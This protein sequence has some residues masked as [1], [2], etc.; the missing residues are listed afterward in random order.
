MRFFSWRRA[1][2]GGVISLVVAAT[3]GV[4]LPPGGATVT[5]TASPSIVVDATQ[6]GHQI[7]PGLYGENQ[8]FT[9]GGK[10][11]LDLSSIAANPTIV[12]I[13]A[14]VLAW[15]QTQ[16]FTGL[17]FPGG[18]VAITYN[19]HNGL[20]PVLDRPTCTNTAGPPTACNSY[21]I[22]EA[23]ELV[24]A[25][26]PQAVFGTEMVLNS[27]TTAQDA[28]DFVQFV[29][30]PDNGSN[31]WAALRAQYGHPAPY[32][33]HY[34]VI[35]NEVH[36]SSVNYPSATYW[37]NGYS[38]NGKVR[39]DGAL[40]IMQAMK[41]VDPTI[42]VGSGWSMRRSYDLIDALQAEGARFDFLDIHNLTGGHGKGTTLTVQH[43]SAIQAATGVSDLTVALDNLINSSQYSALNGM[44]V[45]SSEVDVSDIAL[46]Y[47][48]AH[49]LD[50]AVMLNSFIANGL[51]FE[52]NSPLSSLFSIP[53][54]SARS[55]DL[56][57]YP[58]PANDPEG[59]A[60]PAGDPYIN[61]VASAPSLTNALYANDLGVQSV[62]SSITSTPTEPLGKGTVDTLYVTAALNAAGDVLGIIVT[63]AD[64]NLSWTVPVTVDGFSGT[65]ATVQQIDGPSITSQNDLGSPTTV[66]QVSL[67]GFTVTGNSF[68]YTFPAHS[69]TAIDLAVT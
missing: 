42:A 54:G 65:N 23:M 45:F 17:R 27:T 46:R 66:Q 5:T 28:A 15:A 16:G 19:W 64:M 34:W 49:T 29:N 63:N 32:G 26:G 56:Q 24:E 31:P 44:P 33:V 13:R 12:P 36:P 21:G 53:P 30:A 67:P 7:S 25:L 11:V 3:C 35:G 37:L 6:L 60:Q 22:M 69:V 38:V 8:V 48:L 2:R 50:N 57:W 58:G 61:W 18:S 41:A 1:G 55:E 14:D 9:A 51:Q 4:L 68:S 52:E 47:D 59:A 43:Y 40:N 10:G 20:G 62:F 39:W